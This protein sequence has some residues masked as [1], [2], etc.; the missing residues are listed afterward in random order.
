MKEASGFNRKVTEPS[1]TDVNLPRPRMIHD[2]RLTGRQ[3]LRVVTSRE[4]LLRVALSDD[5]L[6]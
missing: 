6:S 4:W 3:L 1:N 2:F 5:Y